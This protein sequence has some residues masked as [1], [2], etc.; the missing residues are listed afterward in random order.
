MT[1]FARRSIQSF[2][3]GVNSILSQSQIQGLVNR[4]NLN[5]RDSVA[6]EW[7]IAILFALMKLGNVSYEPKMMGKRNPDILFTS[8][9]ETGIQF[10]ADVT[11]VSDADLEDNN[12]IFELSQL[13]AT[14]ARRLGI[15]GAFSFAPEFT[16]AG[17]Y[18]AFKVQLSIPHKT[19]LPVFVRDHI[20]P[21]LRSIAKKPHE[22]RE[23][24]I[25]SADCSLA[26]RY[27][28]GQRFSHANYRAYRVAT[29]IDKNPLFYALESKRKQLRD[30]HYE[31]CR[32]I[33]VCDGG[34]EILTKNSTNWESYS[35]SQILRK[36]FYKTDSISFII[37]LWVEQS[38][39]PH[40]NPRPHRVMGDLIINPHGKSP[41]PKELEELLKEL[42]RHWPQPVQTGE[43]TRAEREGYDPK[44]VP[45]YWGRRLGGHQMG[46][47]HSS[48]TYRMSAR[49][50][51]EILSGRRSHEAFEEDAGFAAPIRGGSPMN[52]FENA[53]R[54]GLTISVVKI[55][56]N[57]DLD[58][59]WIEFR[60]EGPDAA[61]APFHVPSS[62]PK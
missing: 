27:M 18:G 46:I 62:K 5:K 32:G 30:T 23:F 7:E 59:D 48:L 61:L 9:L 43:R 44:N 49:E 25:I 55:E 20:M 24:N 13:V 51:M 19:N 14:K 50:L 21:H 36:F 6:A 45:A 57:S 12:P 11:L 35:K 15:P 22:R 26:L 16:T 54:R 58:D 4:L 33:I 10:V 28:P 29:R 52:P 53:L 47:E 39:D 1:M 37:L 60:M 17:K 40:A 8:K 42:P 2:L 31:G 3:E 56:R 41:V 38:S 34:C